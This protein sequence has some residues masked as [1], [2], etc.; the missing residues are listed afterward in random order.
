MKWL[1]FGLC[2]ALVLGGAVGCVTASTFTE[3]DRE[4][5]HQVKGANEDAIEVLERAQATVPEKSETWTLIGLGIRNLQEVERAAEYLQEVHGPPK[6][7]KPFTPENLTAAIAKSEEEHASSSFSN[8]LVGGLGI[9]A[10][11]AGA[12]FGMPWLATLVPKLTGKVGELAKTG[13]E[14]ITA[15]RKKAEEGG[16][17][18]SV[19]DLLSIAKEYNVSAGV[20]DLAKKAATAYEEKLGFNPTIK[21]Q[22]PEPIPTGAT[23]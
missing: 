4:V 12:F 16:G 7:P 22:E 13:V 14:I 23:T 9:A 5:V 11:A 6:E 17:R 18:I 1:T 2:M 20:D 15:A 21:L 10:G 3:G 8:I 19:K